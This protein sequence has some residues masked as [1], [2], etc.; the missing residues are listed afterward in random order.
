MKAGEGPAKVRAKLE[1][2]LEN[3]LKATAPIYLQKQLTP[4][5][6]VCIASVGDFSNP[7]A[8]WL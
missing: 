7:F 3:Y 5:Y 1:R 2:T 8:G 6:P 4:T